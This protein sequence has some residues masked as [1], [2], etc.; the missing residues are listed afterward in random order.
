MKQSPLTNVA[1][2]P[3]PPDTH[4]ETPDDDTIDIGALFATLWRGKWI[5]L[6]TTLI[7]IAVG[8]YY[9]YVAATPLYTSSAVVM[10][11]TDQ[12]SVVDLESVVGGLTGDSTEVNS[13]L[14]VLKSRGL[15]GKVVDKLDLVS[16][17]EFNVTLSCPRRSMG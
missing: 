7:A 10:L 11:E 8:G 16:D 15:M 17:P 1:Q 14:E 2:I 13:E 12:K 5:M 9:A 6:L 4:S 3:P